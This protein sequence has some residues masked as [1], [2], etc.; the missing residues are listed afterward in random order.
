MKI[1]EKFK[2]NNREIKEKSKINQRKIV[3]RILTVERIQSYPIVCPSS[4]TIFLPYYHYLT[5]TTVLS[6]NIFILLPLPYQALT[7]KGLSSVD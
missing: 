5:P 4:Y 7:P 3:C 2:K 1:K 6:H